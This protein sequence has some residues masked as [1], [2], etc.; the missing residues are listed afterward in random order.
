[1]GTNCAPL[2]ADLFLYCYESEFMLELSKTKQVDL[3]NCFNL[4][5]RYNDDIHNLDN[6]LFEQYI[7]KI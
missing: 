7:H 2:I 3:I 1:M 6:P 5:S 4:T